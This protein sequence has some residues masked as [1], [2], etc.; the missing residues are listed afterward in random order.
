MGG[1]SSSTNPNAHL[2]ALRIQLENYEACSGEEIVGTV[3]LLVHEPIKADALHIEFSGDM[4][5]RY[6][7]DSTKVG[8]M[9][10]PISHHEHKDIIC[11]NK[12]L[13]VWPDHVIPVGQYSL[14][15]RL[16]LPFDIPS[17][18]N[19]VHVKRM[20]SSLLSDTESMAR[21]TYKLTVWALPGIQDTVNIGVHQAAG[22]S[23]YETTLQKSSEVS[24]WCSSKGKVNVDL[25]I[26][27][28]TYFLGEDIDLRM[29]LDLTQSK[30]RPESFRAV[31]RYRMKLSTYISSD[32]TVGTIDTSSAVVDP[33]AVE[34]VLVFKLKLH[35]D[36]AGTISTLHSELINCD[37]FIVI[38]PVHDSWCVCYDDLSME[39]KVAVNSR[40]PAQTQPVPPSNWQPAEIQGAVVVFNQSDVKPGPTAPSH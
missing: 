25:Q 3:G 29:S 20:R 31:L 2:G 39:M 21:V 36:H 6:T 15:F 30:I 26:N 32:T 34:Q 19:W 16:K 7:E 5:V 27:K 35:A 28:A 8:R 18:M 10:I 38:E 4:E 13:N 33:K 9:R 17:S 1:S 37:F 11:F 24:H 40:L 12:P 23:T 22:L 14:P